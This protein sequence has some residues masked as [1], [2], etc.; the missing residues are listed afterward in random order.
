VDTVAATVPVIRNPTEA[1]CGAIAELLWSIREHISSPGDGDT[2]LVMMDLSLDLEAILLRTVPEWRPENIGGLVALNAVLAKA[3]AGCGFIEVWEWGQLQPLLKAADS[4]ETLAAFS[5]R[6]DATRRAVEW[7]GAMTRAS[8]DLVVA[9]H[10]DF[11][12]LALGFVDDRIRSSILLPLGDAAGRLIRERA[13]LAGVTNHVFDLG[14]DVQIRGLNPGFAVGELEVLT[15]MSGEVSFSPEKIYVLPYPPA[16]LEPVAGIISIS[17][18]NAVSHVHLLARNLGIPNAAIT[19]RTFERLL[20]YAGDRVFYAVSPQGKVV[21][22]PETEMTKEEEDL[23]GTGRR[24]EQKIA[25]PTD[26]LNIDIARAVTLDS[27]R[28]SDSGR[29]CGPKAANLGQLKHLFPQRVAPG[30]VIPFGVFRRHMDRPMPG[31]DESYWQFLE[32]TFRRAQR[33]RE[34]TGSEEAV[35]RYVLS[36]L[37]LL[38]DAIGRMPVLP[39]GRE[40]FARVFYEVFGDSLGRVPVFI[41]SDTNM[42][43]LAD[44][45]GAGLNLTEVNVVAEG[46]ILQAIRHVWASPFSERSYRWRQRYLANPENVFPSI[47][48]LRSIDV[49]KSGVMITTGLE[50]ANPNDVTVAF[51]RGAGGAVAGQAA[52]M[53]LLREDGTDILLAPARAAQYTRLPPAGGTTR[54]YTG[55]SR[56]ILTAEE[57]AVLRALAGEIEHELA[58]ILGEDFEGPYDIELGFAGG[59]VWLFQVRPLVENERA[60]S[61]AYLRAMDTEPPQGVRVSPGD[62]VHTRNG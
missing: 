50:S 8:Y 29:I 56:P 17:E 35:A 49:D 16:D 15:E 21:I 44:F 34:S 38:R 51:N 48:I 57:R 30:L 45:S 55:F 18:G 3:A 28:A 60:R 40:D 5:Q 58:G 13:R 10:A 31:T 9:R 36:R 22:K 46:N 39:E 12:P 19:Q 37:S 14:G 26:K 62:A 43:D 6:V 54:E 61:S 33:H 11:E 1:K 25:V 24:A 53:Y 47:L 23:V 32:E 59:K 52:E 2:R 41:R 20:G 27:L 7:G 4:T 42:E